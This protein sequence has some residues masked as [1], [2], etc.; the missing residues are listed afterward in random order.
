MEEET[1]PRRGAAVLSGGELS[2]LGQLLHARL[3]N[4]HLLT[5]SHQTLQPCD[6]GTISPHFIGEVKETSKVI[7]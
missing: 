7:W 4:R 5:Q 1:V 3:C 2:S 6:M